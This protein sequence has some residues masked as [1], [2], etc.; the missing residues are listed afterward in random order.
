MRDSVQLLRW[1][2]KKSV[3]FG[4]GLNDRQVFSGHFLIFCGVAGGQNTHSKESGCMAGYGAG[5]Y[6]W[7]RGGFT[8]GYLA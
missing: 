5:L 6:G 4:S 8:Q 1:A 2:G 3:A 7:L